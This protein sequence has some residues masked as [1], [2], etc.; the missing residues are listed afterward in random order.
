MKIEPYHPFPRS[1]TY[2]ECVH[3]CAEAI[4]EDYPIHA[5]SPGLAATAFALSLAFNRSV[6]EVHDDIVMMM[7]P[8][9]RVVRGGSTRKPK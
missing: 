1:F 5:Q 2:D 3:A 4:A 9:D 8:C 6:G 7:R